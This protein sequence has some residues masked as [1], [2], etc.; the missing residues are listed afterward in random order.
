[1]EWLLQNLVSILALGVSMVALWASYRSAQRS[2]GLERANTLVQIYDRMRPGREAMAVIWRRWAPEGRKAAHL[3][4]AE[5][6]EFED[7]YNAH[8]HNASDPADKR[9]SDDIH[10]LLHELHHVY[11]R[12]EKGDFSLDRV[13]GTFGHA[14]A[15]DQHWLSLYLEAHWRD[16]GELAKSRETRFWNKVPAMLD[17][18]ADW[19]APPVAGQSA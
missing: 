15:M 10:T 7:Y 18:A 11:E 13:L 19:T 5:R 4:P 14:V 9:L 12:T 8:F 17:A 2:A 6:K 1:M 16:H 3:T